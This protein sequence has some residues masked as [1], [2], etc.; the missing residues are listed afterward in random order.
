MYFAKTYIW[1]LDAIY[2]KLFYISCLYADDSIFR[3][4]LY[5]PVPYTEWIDMT[6]SMRSLCIEHDKWFYTIDGMLHDDEL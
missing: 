4:R 5:P 3:F 1:Y 6:R 2:R